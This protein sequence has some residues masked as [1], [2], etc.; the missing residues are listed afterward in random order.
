M[1]LDQANRSDTE[2]VIGEQKSEA[3]RAD[4]DESGDEP[5]VE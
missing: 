4:R 3:T 1:S 5:H 2:P